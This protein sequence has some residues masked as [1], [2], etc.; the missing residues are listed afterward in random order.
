MKPNKPPPHLSPEAK[1]IWAKLCEEFTLT[2]AGALELLRAGLESFDRA[3]AAR[4]LIEKHGLVIMD[5]FGVVKANPL[6]SCE[7]DSRA[8][9]VHALKVLGMDIIDSPATGPGR[10]PR[11]Y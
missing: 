4:I 11:G 2:D 5:R 3:Q 1:S 6:L 9:Y 7:R 8:A 10:P